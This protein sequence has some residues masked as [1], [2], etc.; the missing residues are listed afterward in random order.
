MWCSAPKFRITESMTKI[1]IPVFR[2]RIRLKIR[3]M[4]MIMIRVTEFKITEDQVSG[5]KMKALLVHQGLPDALKGD[6]GE[7]SITDGEESSSVA[8][9]RA[10]MVEKAHSAIILCLGDKALRKV[11]KESTVKGV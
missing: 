2:Q 1:R 10:K 6:S 11:Y 5:I 7:S 9:E 4:I 8:A 3:I